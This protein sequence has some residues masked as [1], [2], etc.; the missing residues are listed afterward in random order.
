M[1][2]T[3]QYLYGVDPASFKNMSWIEALKYRKELASKLLKKVTGEQAAAF[4]KGESDKVLELNEY[5][6][7]L[8]RAISFNE[9]LIEEIERSEKETQQA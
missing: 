2:H 5:Q 8:L 1:K 4:R 6:N 9:K 7:D 3:T